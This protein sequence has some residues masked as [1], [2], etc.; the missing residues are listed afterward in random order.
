MTVF[1][2]KLLIQGLVTHATIEVVTVLD[3]SVKWFFN[4]GGTLTQNR[5][6]GSVFFVVFAMILVMCLILRPQRWDFV[7]FCIRDS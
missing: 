1:S 5:R 2:S 6:K 3:E 7:F 4:D